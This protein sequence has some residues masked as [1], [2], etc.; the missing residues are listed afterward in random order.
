MSG[1]TPLLL[2]GINKE[3][4]ILA[5]AKFSTLCSKR[6]RTVQDTQQ[7]KPRFIFARRS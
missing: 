3:N 4:L 7:P 2:Y 5:Q 1:A 6:S